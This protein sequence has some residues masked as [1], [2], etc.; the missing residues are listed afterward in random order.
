MPFFFLTLHMQQLHTSLRG[1]CCRMKQVFDFSFLFNPSYKLSSFLFLFL[2]LSPFPSN[3][4][5]LGTAQTRTLYLYSSKWK[6]ICV[7]SDNNSYFKDG[8][9]DRTTTYNLEL[10]QQNNICLDEAVFY[11]LRSVKMRARV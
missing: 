2:F 3:L 11:F 7:I 5:L 9:M 6:F 1:N 8:W 10:E 4:V